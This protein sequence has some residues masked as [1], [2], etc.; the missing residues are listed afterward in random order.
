MLLLHLLD[1]SFEFS[2]IV[3][4]GRKGTHREAQR[5][6]RGGIHYGL[7]HLSVS[8][9]IQSASPGEKRANI[10]IDLRDGRE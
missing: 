10:S 4:I 5:R 8:D 7:F 9:K 1:H 2:D 6:Y 3:R